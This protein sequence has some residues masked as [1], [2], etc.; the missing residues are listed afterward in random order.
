MN[1]LIYT[2]P[3]KKR[4]LLYQAQRYVQ[5]YVENNRGSIE[6]IARRT[7][8]AVRQILSGAAPNPGKRPSSTID[9]YF[10]KKKQKTNEAQTV[11]EIDEEETR[12][13][14]MTDQ[15]GDLTKYSFRHYMRKYRNPGGLA[16]FKYLMQRTGI[17]TT[18]SGRQATAKMDSHVNK[19]QFIDN[20]TFPAPSVDQWNWNAF[21]VN[22]FKL[23]PY[24]QL[25]PSNIFGSVNNQPDGNKTYLKKIQSHIMVSNMTN[26][27]CS[28][29]LHWV[30][31]KK[32][33]AL[34]PIDMWGQA[35]TQKRLLLTDPTQ[36][37]QSETS[38]FYVSHEGTSPLV[39]GESPYAHS[40]W[41]KFWKPIHRK[42]FQ[43]DG[44]EQRRIS[45]KIDYNK[46]L[47]KDEMLHSGA[48][49][50]ANQTI[51]VFA[52]LRPGV[53]LATV[54][55]ERATTGIGKI[56]YT[57]SNNYIFQ[58]VPEQRVSTNVATLTFAANAVTKTMENDGDVATVTSVS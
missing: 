20:D 21:P 45:Y 50:W 35:M 41:R 9:Q 49:Y 40:D 58:G 29:E 14:I 51:V 52:I 26:L 55:T 46:M 32:D 39:Y 10:P 3:P 16:T 22:G 13:R 48:N 44:C 12:P 15:K 36:P 7:R 2:L 1:A 24:H 53:A 47:K 25:P 28:L 19:F 27:P 34:D 57:I 6:S 4:A 5:T 54:G 17:F 56:G 11:V 43:L 30:V 8:S 37:Q 18:V 23:N 33:C 31:C 42:E 38:T